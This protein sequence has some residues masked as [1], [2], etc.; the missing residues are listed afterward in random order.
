[1]DGRRRRS[2][3]GR[4]RGVRRT[5][6]LM[7]GLLIRLRQRLRPHLISARLLHRAVDPIR[8]VISSVID[9]AGTVCGWYRVVILFQEFSILFI[10]VIVFKEH[11]GL[12]VEP[13]L[14]RP[15]LDLS[16]IGVSRRCCCCRRRLYRIG[17]AFIQIILRNDLAL[18]ARLSL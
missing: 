9:I 7:S 1:M 15:R 12:Q 6:L 14:L 13:N 11:I 3:Y 10:L 18:T 16:R 8:V 17:I 2:R 5:R 4:P